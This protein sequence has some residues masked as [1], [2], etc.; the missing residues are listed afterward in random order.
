MSSNS[1]GTELVSDFEMRKKIEYVSPS[2]HPTYTNCPSTGHFTPSTGQ[3]RLGN[4][5][6][7]SEKRTGQQTFDC[8]S[9]ELWTFF[10]VVFFL[11]VI[12]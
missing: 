11:V 8:N 12:A 5:H 2:A 9:C 1:Q 7:T 4:N 10:V 6:T 3:Q